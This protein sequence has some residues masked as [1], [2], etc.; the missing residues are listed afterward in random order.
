[1][2]SAQHTQAT[3]VP[4]AMAAFSS[5]RAGPWF[6]GSERCR[7]TTTG[8]RGSPAWLSSASGCSF[9]DRMTSAA[10]MDRAVSASSGPLKTFAATVP[11]T[12]PA[13]RPSEVTPTPAAVS[14]R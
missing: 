13:V 6:S 4:S 7:P 1:M 14:A 10:A 9:S 5:A 3:T 11:S 2:D 12:S 8:R